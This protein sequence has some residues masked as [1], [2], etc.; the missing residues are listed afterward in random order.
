MNPGGIRAALALPAD[1]QLRYEDLFTVQPFY[2]NLVTLTL[3]GGQVLELL[4]QQWQQPSPRI[5]HVSQGFAYTWDAT[6]PV[7][8]R[9]V[10]GSVRLHGQPLDPAAP[11]RVTVNSY[12]AGGGD[13]FVLLK[14]G[15]DARTGLMNV[16]ALELFVKNNPLLVPGPL[17]RVSRLN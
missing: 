2:N 4:E 8:Q 14:Q 10:P 17:D 16:D 13:S 3:T 5:L 11:Y 6:R 1:G 15:R 7:G 12:L 9:V